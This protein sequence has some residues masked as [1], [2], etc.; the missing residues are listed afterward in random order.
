MDIAT[1]AGIMMIGQTSSSDSSTTSSTSVVELPKPD[2]VEYSDVDNYNGLITEH[3][4]VGKDDAYDLKVGVSFSNK[5]TPN[6][7]I[8]SL[9]FYDK[10]GQ[11]AGYVSFSGFYVG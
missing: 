5:G 11:Y 9:H 4:N 7:Q 3:Y 2:L 6:E 1:A 8:N 10:N